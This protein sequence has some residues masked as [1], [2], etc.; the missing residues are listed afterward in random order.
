MQESREVASQLQAYFAAPLPRI[1]DDG[2][3]QG[4]QGLDRGG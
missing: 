3:D 2:V 4:A 1:Y